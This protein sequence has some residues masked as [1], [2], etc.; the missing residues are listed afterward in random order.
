MPE[1]REIMLFSISQMLN[2]DAAADAFAYSLHGSHAER[3]DLQTRGTVVCVCVFGAGSDFGVGSDFLRK[4]VRISA[5][6]A[7]R[8]LRWRGD[9]RAVLPACKDATRPA[10]SSLF[11]MI[12]Y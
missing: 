7:V 10:R 5:D 6:A 1:I 2:T 11:K 8:A 3:F 12:L 9:D 4:N